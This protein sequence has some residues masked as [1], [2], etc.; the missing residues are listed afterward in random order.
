M[1][2]GE[3]RELKEFVDKVKV[4]APDAEIIL[5]GSKARGDET[6]ESDT[7]ILILLKNLDEEIIKKI[8]DIRFD[9][10]M[11]Y[12][13]IISLLIHSKKEWESFPYNISEIQHF[14]KSEGVKLC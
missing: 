11:K 7:D 13:L 14:I 8:K 10:E 1:R 6:F 5:F 9:I 4:I 12:G 3:K 2:E